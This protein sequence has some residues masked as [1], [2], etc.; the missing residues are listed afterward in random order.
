M[1]VEVSF[2]VPARNAAASITETLHSI[3]AQG[4]PARNQVIVIDD[5]STDQTAAIAAAMRPQLPV[6][7]VVRRAWGGEAAALNS[8]LELAR[9]ALVALVEADVRLEAGWLASLIERL[10]DPTVWGA[11]GLLEPD[12]A[13][14]WIARLAGYEVAERMRGQQPHPVHITSA[15]ALYR[16]SAFERVGHFDP[17]L[18]NASLDSD[19]NRRLRAAGGRLAFEPRARAV[20]HYKPTLLGYLARNWAYGRY[21]SYVDQ[22]QLYPGDRALRFQV[23]LALLLIPALALAPWSVMP[24]LGLAL[25]NLAW[26]CVA[27]VRFWRRYRD[28]AAL[29]YPLVAPLRSLVGGIAF[30]AGWWRRR[31]PR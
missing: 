2:L 27:A 1:A 5:G 30:L 9:G 21:R 22:P 4:D 18:L 19:F 10:R 16:R 26:P 3:A 12:R 20:H 13:D 11:G 7:E 14:R 17:A 23:V 24:L 6:L 28:P 29:A 8:G 25:L 31:R 15:N